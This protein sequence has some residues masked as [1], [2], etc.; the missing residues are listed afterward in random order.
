MKIRRRISCFVFSLFLSFLIAWLF[1]ADSVQALR[2]Q[3]AVSP[4]SVQL[5]NC[6]AWGRCAEKPKLNFFLPPQAGGT[7]D[8]TIHVQIG[9]TEKKFQGWTFTV[10]LPLTSKEGLQISYWTT[11]ALGQPS[12]KRSF[13]MRCLLTDGVGGKYLIELL[14]KQWE[15]DAPGCALVWNTFPDLAAEGFGWQQRLEDPLQLHTVNKY[16]LLAGRLIWS[17]LVDASSCLNKGLLPNGSADTCGETMTKVGVDR[18]QNENNAAIQQAALQAY[19]PARILKGLIAQESQFWPHWEKKDEYGLGMLTDLGVDMTLRWNYGYFF[20]KCTEYFSEL[21]CSQGYQYITEAA[22]KFLRGRLL[23]EIG[24]QAEYRLLGESLYAGCLQSAQLVRNIAKKE[25][26]EV[27]SFENMWRI[28]LGVYHA[29]CG[30]LYDAMQNSWKTNKN[31][32]WANINRH[33]TGVCQ[34][35]GDY[36]DRIA[37]L[38]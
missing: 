32:E 13:Y 28:T 29:G 7:S 24:T 25:P 17:G 34:T 14:D 3:L 18:W 10:E 16:P 36:F 23:T 1:P 37:R 2:E 26:R 22:Q 21:Y 5:V 19:I 33:L 12:D 38:G 8:L 30:C 15:A 27:T 9:P 31:F 4:L 6:P 35:A 20:S 11:N